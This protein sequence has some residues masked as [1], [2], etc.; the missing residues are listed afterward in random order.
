MLVF[1]FYTREEGSEQQ[2]TEKKIKS[3][4]SIEEMKK[5]NDDSC[6]TE[7]NGLLDKQSRKIL[8]YSSV[9]LSLLT[10]G[11]VVFRKRQ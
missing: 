2:Q 10:V 1:I 11:F 4:D 7:T 8:L 3:K 5:K 6:R 9:V